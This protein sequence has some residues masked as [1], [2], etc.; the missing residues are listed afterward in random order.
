MR[1]KIFVSVCCWFMLTAAN[2]QID[3]NK[4]FFNGKQFFREGKYNLAME[5]F[6]PLIPYDQN[7]PFSE[8]ASFYYG[9]AA[10][11]QGY[12][13]V[14][15][16]QF[17]QLKTTHPKWDRMDEVN[18]WLGKIHLDNRDYFQAMKIF[19]LIQNAQ[20]SKDVDAAKY[21]AFVSVGDVET[22]RMLN[23]ENPKDEIIG[24]LLAKALSKDLSDPVNKQ[25]LET[26]ITRFNLK[27][28]EYFIEAPKTF[29][30][31]IYSVSVLMPF[32]AKT[33]EPTAAK[34]RNQIILDFYEG[35]KLAVDTLSQQGVKISLRAYDTERDPAKIKTILETE[36][37][38]NT[39][40][41]IGPFF[42][43]ENK[44]MQDFSAANRINLINPFFSNSEYIANNP[45]G[46][47]FQPSVETIGKKAGEFLAAY[48]LKKK[49]CFV[50]YGAGKRD[51][52]LAASF[53]QS[54]REKG[55]NIVS[56]RLIPKENVK[57][58]TTILATPTE[59]DEFRYPKEFT[60]KKDSLGSIFVAS[61]DPL[62]YAKVVSS[63]ETR[64]DQT[65]II[66]SESWLDQ[67]VIDFEKY[68]SLPIILTSPNYTSPT[69]PDYRAFLKKYIRVH[70]RIP[71]ANAKTGYE[72]MLLMGNQLK[73]NG[74]YFQ[75][76]LNEQN[77]VPGY[78]CEGY[79]FQ[80]SR[81]NQ[82][83]PFIRY[84][85]NGMKVIDKR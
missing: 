70:G 27:R 44:V 17:A 30:K 22:L 6:K 47:L 49:N 16:D 58:I 13:S 46:F 15:R 61:D 5:T 59:Y 81:N 60:L 8:Y 55:I 24:K 3:Y 35:L 64:N 10:Y 66:G 38:K 20:F 45:F 25:L 72:L 36:E 73:S 39:D 32:M 53:I 4:Q 65:V 56:S 14:A 52:V 50:F 82:L 21:H 69:D 7:N 28:E 9:V 34:K 31:D 71:S 68:Q 54:A 37:L 51:S 19:A 77:F 62:L 67:T 83:V 84:Q 85:D 43:E 76:A 18:Y 26:L 78:L 48:P 23:E 33:L 40:L 11:Q 74:V 2:A 75:E 12:K 42:P 79:N 63:V 29:K 80:F 57:S 41:M 1:K